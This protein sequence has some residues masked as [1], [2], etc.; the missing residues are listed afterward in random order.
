MD[1]GI[2]LYALQF[3]IPG[4]FAGS[5]DIVRVIDWEIGKL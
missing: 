4:I 5:L 2:V 1:K 3:L